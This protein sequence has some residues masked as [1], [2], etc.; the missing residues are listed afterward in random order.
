MESSGGQFTFLRA[1]NPIGT[2]HIGPTRR[3]RPILRDTSIGVFVTDMRRIN[4]D[5][6]M[7][8]SLAPEHY[9]RLKTNG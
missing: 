9:A 5:A 3:D 4:L 1:P 6:K 2:E 7:R 8:L